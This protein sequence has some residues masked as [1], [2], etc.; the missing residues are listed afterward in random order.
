MPA[1]TLRQIA[2]RCRVNVSTVSRAL[3][4]QGSIPPATQ[5]RVR[6]VAIAM[7]WAPNP[8]AAA[9]M[10]HLRSTRR[11]AQ[12]TTLGFII[13]AQG[14]GR[15]DALP[16]HVALHLE[17]A[18]RQAASYG[19]EIQPMHAGGPDLPWERVDCMLYARNIPGM[20]VSSFRDPSTVIREVEWSRYAAI[21]L[22]N[23]LA[24]PRLH[25][26]AANTHHGFAMMIA[27]AYDLGYRRLAVIISDD[28][29]R[30]VDHGVLFPVAYARERLTAGRW[31]GSLVLPQDAPD[32]RSRAGRWLV[33]H[34]PQVVIG[35]D[36]AW[37]AIR[38]LGWR[39]PQDVAFISVDRSP[40]YPQVAGFNQGHEIHGCLAVD[41]LVAMLT[42]NQRGIPEHPVLQLVDGCWE[43]GASAPAALPHCRKT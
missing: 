39:I 43:D 3:R 32:P 35:T 10:A 9:Y 19:Y 25:R 40:A 15:K 31:L 37:D 13:D 4:S 27:K 1:P 14:V 22:G 26:I 5:I 33:C 29:D 11:P 7:G 42:H 8:L 34:R 16:G 2:A 6:Q 24:Y 12:A 18:R 20:I 38:A 36:I 28:Y 21:A 17:G 41:A 23:T 30:R